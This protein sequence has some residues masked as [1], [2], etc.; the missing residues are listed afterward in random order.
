MPKKCGHCGQKTREQLVQIQLE[1]ICLICSPSFSPL[2][3]LG[4]IRRVANARQWWWG[5]DVQV[6]HG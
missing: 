4:V 2:P 1:T 6:F 3:V 5:L